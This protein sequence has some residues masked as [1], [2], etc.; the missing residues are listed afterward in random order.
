MNLR[1]KRIQRVDVFFHMFPCVFG[2]FMLKINLVDQTSMFAQITWVHK[3]IGADYHHYDA[4][5]CLL[6]IIIIIILPLFA[7]ITWCIFNPSRQVAMLAQYPNTNTSSD[8]R[9]IWCNLFSNKHALYYPKIQQ[10]TKIFQT[11][12]RGG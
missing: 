2:P 10:E 1:H 12:G 6:I 4:F 3:L 5:F 8:L 11:L 9:L 7:Q